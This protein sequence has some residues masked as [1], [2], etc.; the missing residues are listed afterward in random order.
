MSFF[1]DINGLNAKAMKM[2]ET[3]EENKENDCEFDFCLNGADDAI[4]TEDANS[5]NS[6]QKFDYDKADIQAVIEEYM[7]NYNMTA[8]EAEDYI[9]KNINTEG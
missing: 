4:F 7:Y 5:N 8:E 2:F 6:V 3:K 9:S 1:S